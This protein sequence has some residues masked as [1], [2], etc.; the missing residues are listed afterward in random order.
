MF[1]ESM[2]KEIQHSVGTLSEKKGTKTAE[3]A[4]NPAACTI[5]CKFNS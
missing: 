3:C 1:K 5:N 2:N 4:G